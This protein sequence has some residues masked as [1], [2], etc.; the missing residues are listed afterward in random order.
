MGGGEFHRCAGATVL[1]ALETSC[2]SFSG[3]PTH[4]IHA[5]IPWT[6]ALTCAHPSLAEALME[7]AGRI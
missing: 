1:P 3:T 6:I 2:N 5:S 4:P 7:D